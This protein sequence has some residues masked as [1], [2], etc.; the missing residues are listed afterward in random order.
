[1]RKALPIL[2]LLLL[3][4][5]IAEYLSG[6]LAASMLVILWLMAAMY[7][8]AALLIREIAVR[9]GGG[10]PAIVLLGAAYGF[11]EEGWA[12]QSLFNP[13]Y[14]GLRLLDFGYVAAL[15]TGIP[16][17][18]YVIAIHVVWSISTPIALTNC[19]F[20][21]RRHEPWLARWGMALF[22]LLYLA[23]SLMVARYTSMTT[24]FFASPGQ[25]IGTGIVVAVL[26]IAA[27][28]APRW[29]RT[30]AELE[31]PSAPL[32]MLIGFLPG[33]ALVVLEYFGR[34]ALN[35]SAPAAVAM[36][37][38][39]GAASI[40]ALVRLNRRRWSNA[41]YFAV[42]AGL[43]LV[44]AISGFVTSATLHGPAD[45]PGHAVIAIVCLA[46]LGIAWRRS[47]TAIA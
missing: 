37:V 40:V 10:W 11:I 34:R 12:D 47:A 39:V 2:S 42:T 1:M 9:T 28:L 35:L 13:T 30:E 7:G 16:W 26:V 25:L 8:S 19:L 20:P 21:A 14:Q 3:S 4:P 38:L 27:L 5:L 17:L 36:L 41:Q 18:L 6:S 32:L 23:S 22:A 44:Y 29:Q 33:A 45:L 43:V 31:A 24:H 15:G 46:A